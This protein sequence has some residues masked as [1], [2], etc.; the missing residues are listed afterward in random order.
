MKGRRSCTDVIQTLRKHKC[1]R[2]LLY[3]SKLSI[4]I[5]GETKVF[6]NKTKFTHYLSTNPALQK[7]ITEKTKTKTKTT[8]T[9]KQYKDGNHVLENARR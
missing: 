9:K 1:Q 6:H 4:T 5:K 8:T 7:I 2:R 3:P